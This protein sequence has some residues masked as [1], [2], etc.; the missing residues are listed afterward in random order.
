M[1]NGLVM[2]FGCFMK[3]IKRRMVLF[4]VAGLGLVLATGCKKSEM[5]T[6]V[7]TTTG[8]IGDLVRAVAGPDVNVVNIIGATDPHSYK[9][10]TSDVIMMRKADVI[11][12]TGLMLEAKMGEILDELAGKGKQKIVALGEVLPEA[13]LIL[14][15]E[16]GSKEFDP[17]VWMDVRLWAYT[18]PAIVEVL[19]EWKP[20][21][22]EEFAANAEKEKARLDALDQYMRY[23]LATVPTE[24]RTLITAHDAFSYFGRKYGIEV[25]GIQGVSTLDEAGQKRLSGLIDMVVNKKISSIF[26]ES[27]VPEK[28]INALIEGAAAKGFTVGKG[29][30][31]YADA[32]G[33]EGS[34]EGTY[35]GMMDHN[36]T[37]IAKALG[38]NPPEGGFQATDGGKK[39]LGAGAEP[40][41][42]AVP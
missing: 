21:K 15:G 40:E 8:M 14:E 38:G 16:A 6:P 3:N 13:R 17:H 11:F 4:L 7:V 1:P 19:S 12:Y 41:P 36:A 42:V 34:Y 32:M 28:N 23:V 26:V 25:E 10:A 37:T 29:G 39:A 35:I 30:Q 18:L 20:A 22:A 33:P 2:G 24:Q 27:S 5:T 31:L 9:P